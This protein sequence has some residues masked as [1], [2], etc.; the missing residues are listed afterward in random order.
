M[1][2]RER[3]H[4]VRVKLPMRAS[5]STAVTARVSGSLR[6]R[7]YAV[8]SGDVTAMSS[9]W[10]TS[11]TCGRN[12]CTRSPGRGRRS[13][14]GRTISAA[15]SAGEHDAPSSSVAAQP[16]TTP[17]PSALRYAAVARARRSSGTPAPT[18]TS[19]NSLTNRGPRNAP[20]PTCPAATALDPRNGVL[21]ISTGAWTAPS[22]ARFPRTRTRRRACDQRAVTALI[23]RSVS[24]G[25]VR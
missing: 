20:L 6:A 24:G 17:L 22:A 16:A 5:A 3:E 2:A 1:A 11:P 8:R 15:A 19:G 14:S 13:L 9:T 18:Y 23:T 25:C 4:R 12:R 7:S 10:R 21:P